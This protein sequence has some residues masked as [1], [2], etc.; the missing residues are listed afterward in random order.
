MWENVTGLEHNLTNLREMKKTTNESNCSCPALS[1]WVFRCLLILL[2][3][4]LIFSEYSRSIHTVVLSFQILFYCLLIVNY[5][6]LFFVNRILSSFLFL[7]HYINFTLSCVIFCSVSFL[8]TESQVF[9]RFKFYY[10]FFLF[11]KMQSNCFRDVLRFCWVCC[12]ENKRHLVEKTS[13]SV[14]CVVQNVRGKKV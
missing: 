13:I 7:D 2:S 14:F 11:W 3:W 1:L 12:E 5:C 8:Y 9:W 10:Y 4:F 6:F